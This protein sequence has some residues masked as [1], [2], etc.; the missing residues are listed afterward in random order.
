MK[1]RFV[2][3]GI[4]LIAVG[5][6][7]VAATVY[8]ELVQEPQWPEDY[9]MQIPTAKYEWR[10][11]N[12]TM[13]RIGFILTVLGIGIIFGVF[14]PLWKRKGARQNERET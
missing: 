7:L 14:S 4:I 13:T 9:H 3:I 5:V 10:S 6:I 11:R 8:Q 2:A 1:T 12:Q